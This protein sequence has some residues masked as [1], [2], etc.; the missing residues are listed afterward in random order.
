MS[1]GRLLIFI[2]LAVAALFLGANVADAGPGNGTYY[3]NSPAGGDS[4]TA[5]RKFV[6]SLPGLGPSNAN[7]LGQYI[8]VA[9]PD[10]V[11]YPGSDYYEIALRNYT[12]KMHSDLPK[13][14]RLRGYVQTNNGTDGAGNN[15]VAPAPI[16]YLGPLIIAQRDRPVRIKFTNELPASGT[17]G[18][19]LPIPVD[20]TIMGAGVGPQSQTCDAVTHIC[21]DTGIND[22]FTENRSVI[23]LHGGNTPW[24]SD[25]TAHQWIT[26]AGDAT[27]Y[28]TGMSKHDVPDMP[29][30]GQGSTTIYYTNQQS[31]RL[32]FYHDHALGIT[33][34]NVYAGVAAGY[35]LTDPVEQQLINSGAIPS[36]QIPL[37]IQDKTFVPQNIAV[38]DS[39]WDTTKWGEYGDLWFPHV[40]ETNQDPN[41]PEG[42]NPFG[43]WDYG[44]WFWPPVTNVTHQPG[45]CPGDA[46]KTCANLPEISAVPEAFMDT[47]L[48]NGTAYP[49]LNV[50]KRRYRFRILNASNDRFLNLQLYFADPSG[51]E[52]KMVPANPSSKLPDRWPTDNRVGG[53]PD[54]KKIGPTMIQIGT[55][56]GFLP[57]PV[58]LPNTP[59]GYNYNRRDIVVLNVENKTLFLGP[60]ERADVIVDFSKA[61]VGSKIILYNDAPAPVPAFD[62]RNDYYAGNPDLTGSGG[63]PSTVKGYGPN[64]RTVMQF[65]VV[66]KSGKLPPETDTYAST[67]DKLRNA[68][69]GLPHAFAASQPVPIVPEKAYGAAAD[70]YVN[71]FD[72]SLTYTPFGSG[73]PVT[74]S[75]LPKAIHEL[76]ET[77]YGRM[78][79]VLGVELPFTN[80]LTQTTIP[81]FY[82]DP[83]TEI[84][85]DGGTQLWK[86]THN[87]VDTHAIHFHLVNVQ[88]LNRVGWD[89]AVRPADPNELG[90]K[91]TVRMNPLE[92]IVVAMQAKKQSVPFAVPVSS[93]PLAPANPLHSGMGF[94]NVDPN[95]NPVTVYNEVT[96]FGWEYVWHCHLLGH[97]EN[98]M[99]RPLVMTGTATTPL[100]AMGLTATV[101]SATRVTLNWTPASA[102]NSAAETG[103][104]IE[105]ADG[106]GVITTAFTTLNTAGQGS[107]S[108]V[109]STAAAGQAYTY[110]VVATNAAGD[111]SSSNWVKVTTAVPGAPF[112]FFATTTAKGVTPQSV[113]LTWNEGSDNEAGF[114]VQRARNAAFTKDLVT[115][116]VQEA[117]AASYTDS[118]V[119]PKTMYYY[120]VRAAN[121]LGV[122]GF[123]KAKSIAT[124]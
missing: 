67:L 116:T 93:R 111:A 68:A 41:V 72:T 106:A 79:A 104:K 89:G 20:A 34:L 21:I 54:P 65:R 56:G 37:I 32:M 58:E 49:Y 60:A 42:A 118:T 85:P 123:T 121:A 74:M 11:T 77:D 122:S 44:P 26:P 24:I 13:A 23:H 43:R 62:S 99:M 12:E 86:I 94:T 50:E 30:P 70:T 47:I 92:D 90:W 48:V 55:E 117:N 81:Y 71:I 75:L 28:P 80:F 73:G 110:R 52:V 10:T 14:T 25:G 61:P 100:A 29:N 88:V 97:E 91:E 114:V 98:D 6:D 119:A 120:R 4:G 78:N 63:A 40:Y 64:T 105:R 45:P 95:N 82:I 124:K 5:L 19:N 115:F 107:T 2:G 3:A 27:I 31:A 8:P 69:T 103:F 108:Y 46:T 102:T 66:G 18:S 15:T 51:K 17:A 22:L 36:V 16:H 87:G 9:V 53:V 96:D 84:I 39:K 7:N 1:K 35:L 76:F 109:D 57:E 59:V 112:N 33:R 38:Q 113:T 83:A 101:D